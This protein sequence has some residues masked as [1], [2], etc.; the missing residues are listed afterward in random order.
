MPVAEQTVKA[1]PSR[2]FGYFEQA[3][4]WIVIFLLAAG[5]FA[6][7]FVQLSDIPP[8]FNRKASQYHLLNIGLL[9]GIAVLIGTLL[10]SQWLPRLRSTRRFILLA[11]TAFLGLEGAL[12]VF[13]NAVVSVTGSPVPLALRNVRVGRETIYLAPPTAESSLGFR[14]PREEPLHPPGYRILFLGSSYVHGSG[15][16]FQTNYPQAVEADLRARFPARDITVFSAGVIAYGTEE[17][18]LLYQYLLD[19]GYHFDAVVLNFGMES[20]PTNDIPGTI[21]R[22]MVGQPQRLHKNWFVR[23]FYPFNTYLFRYLIYLDVTFNE[24]WVDSSAPKGKDATCAITPDFGA[25]DYEHADYYYGLG[26]KAQIA[27]AFK[28]SID[29]VFAIGELAHANGTKFYVTMLP[30]R[31]A[32]LA[33]VQAI[34]A[35]RSSRPMDWTWTRQTVTGRLG[36]TWPVIDLAP[37]FAARPELFRCNDLHWNDAGNLAGARAVADFLATQLRAP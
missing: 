33:Q 12:C 8:V 7:L 11:M 31:A 25:F 13:D 26:A 19:H 21:R 15:S 27:K 16:T 14:T 9:V 22:A 5:F 4:F 10:A 37:Y 36:A 23:Q 32:G 28:Y 6:T 30:D 35:K 3:V 18:R 34:F 24:K 20:D 17:D 1:T 2:Y 29:Q